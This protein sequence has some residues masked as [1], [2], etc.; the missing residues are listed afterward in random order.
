MAR[1]TQVHV[2]GTIDNVIFYTRLGK[3]IGRSRR[4][5]IKQTPAMKK[6]SNRF[7]TASSAGNRLWALLSPVC[8]FPV[9]DTS[10]APFVG[11]I[12]KWLKSSGAEETAASSR[13]PYIQ[14]FSF[15]KETS[16]AER[17]RIKFTAAQ[18]SPG[19]IELT[20]PM[21]TPKQ[22]ISASAN[23]VTVHCT[24]TAA[25]CGLSDKKQNYSHTETRTFSY[26]G[27]IEPAQT[28]LFPVNAKKGCL[29]VLAASLAYTLNNG[30]KETR[31]KFL[32][33]SVIGSWYIG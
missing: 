9:D 13:L 27:I 6:S 17:C 25:C 28:I 33:S 26:T 23:A 21:F 2:E 19:I 30:K 15:S 10:R 7:G 20:I 31:P 22:A 4:S 14:D 32:P 11:A 29:V 24:F 8:S 18:P 3:R 5:S 16:I 1:I 12:A